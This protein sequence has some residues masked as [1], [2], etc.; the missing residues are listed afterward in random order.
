MREAG[1]AKPSPTTEAVVTEVARFLA[2]RRGKNPVVQRE[3][4]RKKSAEVAPSKEVQLDMRR[5][6]RETTYTSHDAKFIAQPTTLESKPAAREALQRAVRLGHGGTLAPLPVFYQDKRL[7]LSN[8][9]TSTCR[10]DLLK[11]LESTEADAWHARRASLFGCNVS[12][13]LLALEEVI[14]PSTPPGMELDEPFHP[15]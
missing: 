11:W 4:R 15:S 1:L 10:E 3:S 13:P 9:A 12:R 14:A 7:A 6:L 5:A 8:R 2:E